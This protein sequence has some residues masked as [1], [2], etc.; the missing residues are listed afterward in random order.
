[1]LLFNVPKKNKGFT[2]VEMVVTAV[3]VG[4]LAAVSVPNLLGLYNQNKVKEGLAQVEGALKEA[5]RQA[6]RRGKSCTVEIDITNSKI[7]NPSSGDGCLLSE[8]IL[9]EGTTL[10]TSLT[11][12]TKTITFS[13]KGNTTNS[14]TI[15]LTMNNT[16][17]KKCLVISNG[18]GIM[19]TGDYDESVS[20]SMADKCITS[21]D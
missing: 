15:V 14:G 20:G 19:R 12:T 13:Y 17:R 11:G 2:L 18:L 3:V 5:Q 4:V 16:E 6:M 7:K 8:R 21:S 1:M 10:S 9:P